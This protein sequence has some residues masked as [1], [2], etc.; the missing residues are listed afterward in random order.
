M[1]CSWPIYRFGAS[2]SKSQ[3]ISPIWVALRPNWRNVDEL[4]RKSDKMLAPLPIQRV[5]DGGWTSSY[6][7]QFWK[8]HLCLLVL[9]CLHRD[10]S[11]GRDPYL[12]LAI[13]GTFPIFVD[14][15]VPNINIRWQNLAELLGFL[16]DSVLYR[17]GTYLPPHFLFLNVPKREW[18]QRKN[19]VCF[20]EEKKTATEVEI[21]LIIGQCYCHRPIWIT[22]FL[23]AFFTTY[24]FFS[25]G[26]C[27]AKW[28]LKSR[29]LISNEA[30]WSASGFWVQAAKTAAGPSYWD[31]VHSVTC[32][33]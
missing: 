30:S 15:F 16:L 2:V 19:N 9:V 3:P 20:V 10:S 23:P 21:Y 22:L 26:H 7:R 1:A 29:S 4:D 24:L 11:G 28:D 31:A 17:S 27:S 32:C 12:S 33:K 5:Q 6:V 8:D 13:T 14:H 18:W 25:S